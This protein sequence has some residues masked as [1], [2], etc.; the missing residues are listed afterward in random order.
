MADTEKTHSRARVTGGS[1]RR[2]NLTPPVSLRGGGVRCRRLPPGPGSRARLLSRPGHAPASGP[3][4]PARLVC[5][6]GCS[7]L[8]H[9]QVLGVTAGGR[10]WR[11]ENPKYLC[12]NQQNP[13]RGGHPRPTGESA[14]TPTNTGRQIHRPTEPRRVEEGVVVAS[15][16]G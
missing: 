2:T 14:Q 10:C 9:L 15:V 6:G 13:G 12:L 16:L 5:G 8:T 1:R 11:W 4:V 7:A 3:L